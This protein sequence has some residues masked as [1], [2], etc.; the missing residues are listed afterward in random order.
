MRSGGTT[1][2]L[3]YRRN[4]N[5]SM[6][7]VSAALALFV[8][9]LACAEHHQASGPESLL[10]FGSMEVPMNKADGE[11]DADTHLSAPLKRWDQKR[12]EFLKRREQRRANILKPREVD[13]GAFSRA[14]VEDPRL[15]IL[16]RK[17]ASA[18][19]QY[20][21]GIEGNTSVVAHAH[22]AQNDAK[23]ADWKRKRAAAFQ[24]HP[25]K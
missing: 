9:T 1:S 7:P 24:L 2:S 13:A 6:R 8:A 15:A 19:Q 21:S 10:E 12:A 22:V 18:R 23:L 14:D 16:K 5:P 11:P 20:T 3:T 17:R 25:E 4:P